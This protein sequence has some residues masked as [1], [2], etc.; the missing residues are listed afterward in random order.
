MFKIISF[1]SMCVF[2]YVMC[3]QLCCC[4]I[5]M[6][7]SETVSPGINLYVEVKHIAYDLLLP[8]HGQLYVF[9]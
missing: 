2:I 4:Y 6:Y 9:H 1:N 3:I 7:A 5:E 8:S